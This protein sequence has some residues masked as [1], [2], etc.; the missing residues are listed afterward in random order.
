MKGLWKNDLGGY[1]K[2]NKRKKQTRRHYIKDNGKAICKRYISEHKNPGRKYDDEIFRIENEVENK[3]TKPDLGIG[4]EV[5]EVDICKIVWYGKIYFAFFYNGWYDEITNE[6]IGP[7]WDPVWGDYQSEPKLLEVIKTVPFDDDIGRK[8]D[9]IV[10][11]GYTGDYTRNEFLYGKPL[12]K[13]DINWGNGRRG[14]IAQKFSHKRDRRI[15]RDWLIKKNYNKEIPT[16]H[17]SKS[18]L[19]ELW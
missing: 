18:L 14:K 1:Y 15:M 13:K 5:F 7:K 6:Y 9:Q 11:D 16:H 17:T 10:Y 4:E 2:D 12:L 3:F 8:K 19:W